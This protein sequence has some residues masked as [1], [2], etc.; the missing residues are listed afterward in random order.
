MIL[1]FNFFIDGSRDPTDL[2]MMPHSYEK[3]RKMEQEID[4][5]EEM[6]NETGSLL[7]APTLSLDLRQLHNSEGWVG[8]FLLPNSE[9]VI[10][11]PCYLIGFNDDCTRALVVLAHYGTDA[12]M[13]YPVFFPT[14]ILPPGSANNSRR[15]AKS[16]KHVGTLMSTFEYEHA[17]VQRSTEEESIKQCEL[18]IKSNLIANHNCDARMCHGIHNGLVMKT[19]ADRNW[20]MLDRNIWFEETDVKVDVFTVNMKTSRERHVFVVETASTRSEAILAKRIARTHKFQMCC[21]ISSLNKVRGALQALKEKTVDATT[22]DSCLQYL[23]SGSA[24]LNFVDGSLIPCKLNHYTCACD[25]VNSNTLSR[26]TKGKRRK[27]HDRK[28]STIERRA[29][30]VSN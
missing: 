25:I 24:T 28:K 21:K 29:T 11:L 18:V 12:E 9:D 2:A 26:V 4:D 3:Y 17:S 10:E 15:F 1:T 7:D 22:A 6:E 14:D 20:Y 8:H 5:M 30:V 27:E 16:L 13:Y 23:L 19:P